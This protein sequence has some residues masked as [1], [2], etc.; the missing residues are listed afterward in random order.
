LAGID[1]MFGGFTES[2]QRKYA[3]CA[4]Q[5]FHL[6]AVRPPKQYGKP[7]SMLCRARESR[8]RFVMG[9][10]QR[11]TIAIRRARPA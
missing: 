10:N 2:L 7:A 6:F 9:A 5:Q 3:P 8:V 11:R 4:L 1:A